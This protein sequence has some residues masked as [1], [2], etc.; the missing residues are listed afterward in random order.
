MEAQVNI[1]I[2]CL[3][4]SSLRY[5]LNG[6]QHECSSL[7]TWL[8]VISPPFWASAFLKRDM[9]LN[10]MIPEVTSSWWQVS[11]KNTYRSLPSSFFLVMGAHCHHRASGSVS[12]YGSSPHMVMGGRLVGSHPLSGITRACPAFLIECPCRAAPRLSLVVAALWTHILL[13]SFPSLSHFF[14]PLPVFSD[15][16]SCGRQKNGPCKVS[17][18]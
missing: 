12:Y 7:V 14:T 16:T 4:H 5:Q 15:V 1:W 11:E 18:S 8:R 2:Q 17:V 10:K 6:S 13:A 9:R 3:T